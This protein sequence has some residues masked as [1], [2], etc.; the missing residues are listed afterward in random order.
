MRPTGI[1]NMDS[2]IALEGLFENLPHCAGGSHL[3]VAVDLHWVP[4]D[5]AATMSDLILPVLQ[6]PQSGGSSA[7]GIGSIS[8]WSGPISVGPSH[9]DP[10]REPG[11]REEARIIARKRLPGRVGPREARPGEEPCRTGERLVLLSGEGMRAR[12]SSADAMNP[13]R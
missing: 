2:E 12:G 8:R 11:E 7:V 1:L 6:V 9:A 10:F 3:G 13:P 4:S 5:V